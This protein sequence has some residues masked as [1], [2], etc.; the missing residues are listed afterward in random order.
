MPAVRDPNGHAGAR[1]GSALDAGPVLGV[2][3]LR[4]AFLVDLPP[5]EEGNTQ[6]GGAPA[7]GGRSTGG[8]DRVVNLGGSPTPVLGL[9]SPKEVPTLAP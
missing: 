9:T 7:G 5:T 6:A 3:E 8:H 2:P 4:T 1:E